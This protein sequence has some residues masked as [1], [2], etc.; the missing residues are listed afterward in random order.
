MNSSFIFTLRLRPGFLES[1]SVS[2][3]VSWL[4]LPHR[5][6]GK[7][8]HTINPPPLCLTG[9]QKNAK[10]NLVK[11]SGRICYK[12][13]L[14]Q[15]GEQTFSCFFSKPTTWSSNLENISLWNFHQHLATVVY[16][17]H[18][19]NKTILRCNAT[20][21]LLPRFCQEEQTQQNFA[22]WLHAAGIQQRPNAQNWN[23]EQITEARQAHGTQ[24]SANICAGKGPDMIQNHFH[25][26]SL[27]NTAGEESVHRNATF[28]R[29]VADGTGGAGMYCSPKQ[30]EEQ[31]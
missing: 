8:A 23:W 11:K 28:S 14:F 12:P 29:S 16:E 7:E 31:G 1:V 3:G 20:E 25:H 13:D 26:H 5:Q 17:S 19:I 6:R 24:T 18:W 15:R 27:Q 21:N 4:Q 9:C 10:N 22:A 2:D 30:K